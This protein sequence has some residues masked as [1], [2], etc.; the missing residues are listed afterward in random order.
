MNELSRQAVLL[1]E[2]RIGSL[3]DLKT[4]RNINS[5]LQG[6]PD[7]NKVPGVDMTT[8]PLGQGI[9]TAVGFALAEARLRERFN[10]YQKDLIDHNQLHYSFLNIQNY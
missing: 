2:N 1:N 4:F 9:A 6:H 3:E 10:K 5:Y 8:G 7:K